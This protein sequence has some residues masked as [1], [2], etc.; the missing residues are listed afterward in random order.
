M[1]NWKRLIA[2]MMLLVLALTMTACSGGDGKKD[3]A[4]ATAKTENFTFWVY[5]GVDSAFYTDYNDNP[6]M[7]YLKDRTW[8]DNQ[9]KVAFNFW[10]PP[11]GTAVDN[12]STMVG[13]GDY[14]DV[15]Q[16]TIGDSAINSYTSG[17][18]M[19]ITEYVQ[20]YMPNYLAFLE[21]NPELKDN[22]I[23]M[24]DGQPRY[25]G[26][27]SVYDDYP[28]QMWG[29]MYRR[30]WIVKYGVHPVTGEAFTGSFTDA[31][32]PDSWKDDVVFPSGGSDPVYISD[33]EWMFKIFQK[34][35]AD[36]G[37]TDSYC[38]SVPYNGFTGVGE[39]S[40]SFGGG[41]S[42]AWFRTLDNVVTYG[43]VTSQWRAY[44]E[45]MNNWYKQGWLD[46]IFDE[47]ASDMF[48][49]I[50]TTS[51]YQGKIGM[52]YGL[53]SQLGNR[54][55]TGD[56]CTKGIAVYAAKTP[57]N[58]IYGGD[59]NKFVEP[60]CGF[61]ASKVL[62][63]YL[64]STKAEGKDLGALLSYFDFF[65]GEEGARLLTL[66]LSKEQYE[67]VKD[68]FMTSRGLVN[69]A[70]TVAEDGRLVVDP[71]IRDDSGDLGGAC[72]CDLMPGMNLVKNV[73]FG[74][75]DGYKHAMAQWS[76]Y[77][78]L[79]FFQ[80]STMMNDMTE[81]E[82]KQYNNQTTKVGDYI[83]AN[84][85]KF[86]KGELDPLNDEDWGNWCTMMKKYG[87]EKIITLVQP[88]ADAHPIYVPTQEAK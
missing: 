72:A 81:K 21:K 7:K 45:C 74:Y 18:S 41:A 53:P 75:S 76:A 12:F 73:D 26:I 31:N 79:G 44:L 2:V 15:I 17:L 77:Q 71:I 28:D 30:D 8:G 10:V 49:A 4:A 1:K 9:S 42:G 29:H 23:T 25:M 68:P 62:T 39:L 58:D 14:A 38:I 59:E 51:V 52:W 63:T 34:A 86:I 6:V 70:Y 22:A 84:A 60:Y 64:I 56:G 27:I 37:L 13:S 32:D 80:G 50:D 83:A 5:K 65:Y 43:P 55:D 54:M 3:D 36:L 85:P 67:E 24:V 69:G 57:I 40:A 66:G 35:Y 78:N 88:H 11:A 19:D 82:T 61:G 20:K 87:Y 16:N 47:R 48:Y 46:P 33:W